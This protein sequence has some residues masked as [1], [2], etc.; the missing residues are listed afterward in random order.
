MTESEMVA[1]YIAAHGV[2]ACQ[3]GAVSQ[4]I[5][6]KGER[7][8]IFAN[9]RVFSYWE[10]DGWNPGDPPE[11]RWPDHAGGSA[12]HDMREWRDAPDME[13]GSQLAAAITSQHPFMFQL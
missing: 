2:T 10:L 5:K 6:F 4:S 1:A 8:G 11:M 3:P 9:D 7:D 12:S 13:R